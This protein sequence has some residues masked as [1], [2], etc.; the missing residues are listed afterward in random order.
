MEGQ[1]P[2]AVKEIW[3]SLATTEM[4]LQMMSELVKLN[5]GLADIEEFNINLTD[6]LKNKPSEKVTEMQNQRLIKA[7]M[8]VKIKDEQTTRSKLIRKRN[9]ARTNL[10]RELG[11]NSKK[12]RRRIRELRKAATDIKVGYRELY[13]EKMITTH[14]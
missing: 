6:N 9:I 3:E 8:S 5:L 1:D 10:M 7:T 14:L 2:S 4:R 11:R 12:Y 13:T